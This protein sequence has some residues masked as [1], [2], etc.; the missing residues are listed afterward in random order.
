ME[1]AGNAFLLAMAGSGVLLWRMQEFGT[2]KTK[3]APPPLQLP[4]PVHSATDKDAF[5]H[6]LHS[7]NVK[8]EQTVPGRRG[9]IV[10]VQGPAGT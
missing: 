9:G 8:D 6:T 1:P 3:N 4:L 2:S 7:P 10:V 5:I